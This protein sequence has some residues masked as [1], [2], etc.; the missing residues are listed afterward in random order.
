[1]NSKSSS[2]P[3]HRPPPSLKSDSRSNSHYFTLT[4]PQILACRALKKSLPDENHVIHN[5]SRKNNDC[6]S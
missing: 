3:Y 1:M 6:G 4:S 2:R 5:I